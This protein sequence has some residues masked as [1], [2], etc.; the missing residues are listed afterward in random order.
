M[1]YTGEMAAGRRLL[2]SDAVVA[3][4]GR[5]GWDSPLLGDFGAAV[6]TK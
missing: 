3:R 6:G 2:L 1:D 4:W 5:Q